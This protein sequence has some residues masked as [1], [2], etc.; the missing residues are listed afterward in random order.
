MG[1]AKT[2]F[3]QACFNSVCRLFT[4]LNTQVL[5]LLLAGLLT[6]QSAFTF[7]SDQIR[8]IQMTDY[9]EDQQLLFDSQVQFHLPKAVIEAIYNEITLTFKTEIV[10]QEHQRFA[11]IKYRRERMHVSYNTQLHY[12]DFSGRYTLVNERNNKVQSFSSLD[13][14]LKTLGTLS[15]F[16]ILGLSE[17]HPAQKYTLKLNINLNRWRLPAPL[18]LNSLLDS[19]WNLNSGWFETRIYTPKSWL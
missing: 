12:S 1:L 17:L 3:I 6:F 9:Q 11:G 10:F 7:A 18:V 14:A 2:R 13:E 8:I 5:R 16:P 4:Q 15:A 19:D